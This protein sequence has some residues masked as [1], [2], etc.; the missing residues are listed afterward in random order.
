LEENETDETGIKL[1]GTWERERWWYQLAHVCLRWRVLV[2]ASPSRL[3]LC[4]LCTYGTPVADMLAHSPTVPLI[5]DYNDI[6]NPDGR[7]LTAEDEKGIQR[8]LQLRDR[9]RRIRLAISLPNLQK[10]IMA[11]ADEFPILECLDIQPPAK[12]H[13]GLRLP[14]TL[15]A[16]LLR[17]LILDNIAFP[18]GSPLLTTA[19]ALVTLMLES[20][21]P[22][23]SAY[24]SPNQLLQRLSLMPQLE[25]LGIGFRSPIPNRDIDRQLI[26]TPIV[27]HVTLPRLRLFLFKGTSAYLEVLLPW[28]TTPNLQRLA[29]AFFN[30]LIFS[31]PHLLHFMTTTED[32]EFNKARITFSAQGVE[33]SVY[34]HEGS[35]V[36][37][38]NTNVT[39]KHLDWQVASAGQILNALRTVFSDVED[40]TLVYWD[41]VKPLEW[42][43]EAYRTQWRGLL[44]PFSK[45][46]ILR[47]D[48]ELIRM[49]TCSL[50]LE[51]G[52]SP[53]LLPELSE[54]SYD[55]TDD[56][57][58]EFASFVDARQT[59]GHPV[60]LV[61]LYQS[62]P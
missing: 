38:Y 14:E 20:I 54:L 53:M 30:Q 47:V 48:H 57:S 60:S 51:D 24:F 40:L 29:I 49:L 25:N 43:Y 46:K 41:S 19:P 59:A 13:T 37:A 17:H 6:N 1:S 56:I 15:Q 34:P 2:L 26:H 18:L 5:I 22:S 39:C 7:E 33:I 23:E 28:I 21:T 27:T 16:P 44:T 55:G 58:D 42:R 9:V 36:H 62:L 10:F 32:V 12:H 35:S 45:V 3:R 8:A 11:I 61:R 31:V 50:Q 52:E 4:L